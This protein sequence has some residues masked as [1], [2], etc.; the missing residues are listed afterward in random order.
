ML[1][2]RQLINFNYVTTHHLTTR[3]LTSEHWIH[4]DLGRKDWTALQN[5]IVSLIIFTY[6]L[7]WRGHWHAWKV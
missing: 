4:L 3:H 1:D 6:K 5:C 2:V 7:D